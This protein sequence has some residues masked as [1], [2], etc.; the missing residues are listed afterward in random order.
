MHFVINARSVTTPTNTVSLTKE[1]DILPGKETFAEE[2]EVGKL[3]QELKSTPV[4]C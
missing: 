1:L 3:L 4:R 2:P